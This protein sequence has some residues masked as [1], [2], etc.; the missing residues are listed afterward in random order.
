MRRLLRSLLARIRDPKAYLRA[1]RWR[2]SW[3][4]PYLWL[5]QDGSVFYG[6]V[7][8]DNFHYIRLHGTRDDGGIIACAESSAREATWLCI[9]RYRP[10]TRPREVYPPTDH[11]ALVDAMRARGTWRGCEDMAPTS[12]LCGRRPTVTPAPTG[13]GERGTP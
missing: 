1:W 13:H 7:S 12:P 6:P 5:A 11:G 4:R 9:G 3:R 8:C 2:R 10:G